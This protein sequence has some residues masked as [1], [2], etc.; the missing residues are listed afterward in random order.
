MGE[1]IMHEEGV[2]VLC[3]ERVLIYREEFKKL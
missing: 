1:D 3:I 2:H